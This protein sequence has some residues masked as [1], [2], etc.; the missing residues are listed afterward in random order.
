MAQIEEVREP[1]KRTKMVISGCATP[2]PFLAQMTV[3]YAEAAQEEVRMAAV[4]FDLLDVPGPLTY[5]ARS[6]QG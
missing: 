2:R 6:C 5:W 1:M 4:T 3:V